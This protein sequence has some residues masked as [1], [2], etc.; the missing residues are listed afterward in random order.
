MVDDTDRD[1]GIRIKYTGGQAGYG[2]Q[3][4]LQCNTS[5]EELAEISLDASD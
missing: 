5:V 2:F 3:L 1:N 4:R